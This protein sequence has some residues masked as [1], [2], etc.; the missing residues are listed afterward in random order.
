MSEEAWSYPLGSR[1]SYNYQ[2][3][4]VS[5]MSFF[6]GC[7]DYPRDK[8]FTKEELLELTPLDIKRWMS[9]IV[10]GDPD[11][12]PDDRPTHGRSASLE[13]AKKA[14]SFFMPNKSMPWCDGRGNPTR[15]AAVNDLIKEVKRFEVRGEGANSQVKRPLRQIEFRKSLELLRRNS[16]HDHRY[17]Y[18]LIALYQ[19]HLIGR[20]D[21]VCNF[22]VKD[23]RGHPQFPFALKTKVSWSKNVRDERR[24]PDQILLG[25]ADPD[26]CIFLAL[27]LHLETYLGVH[28]NATKLFT[29]ATGRNA[30]KNIISQCRNRLRQVVWN[31]EEFKALEDEDD[32]GEGVGTHSYRKHPS[33]Y[34]R[35]CGCV[36]DDVEIRGRWKQSGNRIVN[37]YI[38]VKQLFIDAK[39]AAVLCI[40]GPIAYKLR[41]G[42]VLSDEWL[43]ECV[44]P[45]IRRRFRADTRLCRV[46]ALALL[47][48][49]LDPELKESVP[50][51]M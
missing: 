31:N 34:A 22:D 41:E 39:V 36:A 7:V 8:T 6:H 29:E 4:M 49:S 51:E 10:F 42:V 21:D 50:V 17:K 13:Q 16:D 26:Y 40:G 46:L 30:V 28:P 45:N 33:T 43:F 44:A 47:F 25:S 27:A 23:P 37:R 19:H 1:T 48:A 12:G 38:D 35:A 14:V 24:C 3:Y 5:L 11:P 9:D 32:E 20:V 2:P 18:P 15:S